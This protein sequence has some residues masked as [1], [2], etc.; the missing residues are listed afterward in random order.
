[1]DVPLEDRIKVI[2]EMYAKNSL[3]GFYPCPKCLKWNQNVRSRSVCHVCYCN[4]GCECITKVESCRG[5][6]R[7]V[8]NECAVCLKCYTCRECLNKG[9]GAC[10][11]CDEVK[12]HCTYICDKCGKRVCDKHFVKCPEQYHTGGHHCLNTCM[13]CKRVTCH[14]LVD[15]CYLPAPHVCDY[16][17]CCRAC[18]QKHRDEVRD[19]LIAMHED[20]DLICYLQ[21]N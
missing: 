14:Q 18:Y 4:G 8:C 15:K 13:K 17:K 6:Q 16:Q 7:F 10:E 11:E 5:C 2:K 12:C 3:M 1:M 9:K 21:K 20:F 19:Y